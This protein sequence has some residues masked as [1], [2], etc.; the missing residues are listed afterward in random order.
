MATITQIIQ[1]HVPDLQPYE[2]L[3]KHFHS[4]PELSHQESATAARI[5][6]HL[7]TLGGGGHYTIHA[8]LG[9]HGLAAVLPNGPGPTVLLRADMDALPVLEA[10]GLPYASTDRARDLS[11]GGVEKP[12]MHACGH[13]MHVTALL[14]A[15]E[16]LASARAEWKGT[17]VLVFQPAEERAE[18]ARRMVE[19]GGLYERVPVPDVLVGAH[20]MPFRSGVIGVRGGLVASS[21]DSF[22][23]HLPGRQSHASTPHT[24]LDP[25]LLAA[26]TIIRLQTIVAREV[27]PLDF[28]VVTVSA[29]H[30]GDREN[31]IPASATL[32][33]NIRAAKPATRDRV[34]KSVRRI[35]RA[36]AMA[37]SD[38][39][40]EGMEPR[41]EG[42]NAFPFL[43]NDE[44][45]TAVLQDAFA[46]HFGG[47]EWARFDAEIPR[48]QGSED[49]GLLA[50]S[51]GRP[52]CFFLYGGVEHEVW[53]RLEGE[54]RLAEVPGNHSPGF[55]LQIRP[56][57]DVGV[58]GYVAAALG[59]FREGKVVKERVVEG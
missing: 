54:G 48:L 51:V 42:I 12:V 29:I 32:K 24:S 30:A 57:L 49:F 46:G 34:L 50:T 35:I 1:T 52:S 13:D 23:V 14:A 43:Y 33:L 37:T 2:E 6:Q 41:I 10:T 26:H 59:F 22:E 36:E 25:I 38:E 40:G 17:L 20:V 18:G 39:G 11:D 4:H 7:S 56:T 8:S 47:R 21:A 19:E 5:S 9:G 3:Y 55:R 53:D 44:V 28:A 45:S 16:T 15:A 27:D 58:E 31:I